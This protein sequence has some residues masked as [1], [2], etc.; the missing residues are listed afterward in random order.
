[1]PA[2]LSTSTVLVEETSEDGWS[3][4]LRAYRPRVEEVKAYEMPTLQRVN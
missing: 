1:M 3:F 2:P 4:L